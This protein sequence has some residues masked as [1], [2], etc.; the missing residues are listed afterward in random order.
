M[1]S[2]AAFRAREG[3]RM[4]PAPER[5]DLFCQAVGNCQIMEFEG[6]FCSRPAFERL[7]QQIPKMQVANDRAR[8]PLQLHDLRNR[9]EIKKHRAQAR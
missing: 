7:R 4:M 3:S 8:V 5:G 1:I 9:P 6:C 2:D